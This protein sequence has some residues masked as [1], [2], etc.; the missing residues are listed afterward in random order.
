MRLNSTLAPIASST[1]KSNLMALAVI[2]VLL[3]LLLL[4]KVAIAANPVTDQQADTSKHS[5]SAYAHLASDEVVEISVGEGVAHILVRA[6]DGRKKLGAAILLANPG[7]SASPAGLVDFLRHELP[8]TGWAT[9]S[10]TPPKHIAIPNLVT[11]ADEITKA[12][13]K[14]LSQKSTEA[15]A[16]YS[17]E[18]WQ[19]MREQQEEFI[20]QSMD[21]LDALGGPYPG[22]RLLITTDQGAGLAIS[23]LSRNKLPKPDILIIINPFMINPEENQA[24]AKQL[25][26]LNIPVLDIQS[27]DGHSASKETLEARRRLSPQQAPYLYSQQSLSLDLSQEAAWHTSLKLIEGFAARISKGH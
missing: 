16:L 6:W 24:L 21:K 26:E 17:A 7:M 4:I 20:M 22:K 9:L 2:T 25:G 8:H 13:E 23:L 5:S 12:G 10:L 27:N 1:V 14:Q 19:E 15:I 3:A 18:K 11:Q